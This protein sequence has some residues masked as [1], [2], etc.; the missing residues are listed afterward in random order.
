MESQKISNLLNK[1][2]MILDLWQE[3]ET[4]PTIN[5]AQIML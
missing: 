2:Q 1:K 3:N 5:Q 4:F